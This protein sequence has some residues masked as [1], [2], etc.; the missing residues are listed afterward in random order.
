MLMNTMKSLL[1]VAMKEKDEVSRDILRLVIGDVDGRLARSVKMSEEIVE[2]VI[3]KHI[4]QNN[5]SLAFHKEGDGHYERITTQSKLLNSLLPEAISVERIGE[6]L[7]PI[8]YEILGA[9]N[10]GQAIG[11]GIKHLKALDYAANGSDVKLVVE[12][13]RS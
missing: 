11:L 7:A 10:M 12:K 3:R 13:M 4:K 9:D 5:E 1:L 6:V 8:S 2:S